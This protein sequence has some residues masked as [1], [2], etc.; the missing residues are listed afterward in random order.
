MST[1]NK[2][3]IDKNLFF[4]IHIYTFFAKTGFFIF[5]LKLRLSF[6]GDKLGGAFESTEVSIIL[7][8]P[9]SAS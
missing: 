7:I 2:M 4:A 3:K 5:R 6:I 1:N 9:I 8:T